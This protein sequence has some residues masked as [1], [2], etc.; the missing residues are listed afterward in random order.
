[1]LLFDHNRFGQAAV[2]T[3]AVAKNFC[4]WS[5]GPIRASQCGLQR[6]WVW[7]EG[8]AQRMAVP[9]VSFV[10]GVAP[11]VSYRPPAWVESV[12]G[13]GGARDRGRTLPGLL[14]GNTSELSKQEYPGLYDK[15]DRVEKQLYADCG[16]NQ[17]F[18]EYGH[19]LLGHFLYGVF[20]EA[21]RNGGREESEEEIMTRLSPQAVEVF[22]R[23]SS[24]SEGYTL[25]CN[26]TLTQVRGWGATSKWRD[27]WATLPFFC[28]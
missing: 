16:E 12:G 7:L 19:R 26:L 6:T 15:L 2:L 24:G 23:V 10:H 22:H 3:A 4:W 14:L 9:L 28:V 11:W 20:V 25:S 17:H 27:G 1:M 21:G 13:E 5:D 8:V 18:N